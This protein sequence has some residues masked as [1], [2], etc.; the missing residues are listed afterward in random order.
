MNTPIGLKVWGDVVHGW[1]L[2]D[3]GELLDTQTGRPAGDQRCTPV[4]GGR[5][6]DL[7]ANLPMTNSSM[8]N[9]SDSS[10]EGSIESEVI[11]LM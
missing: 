6:K 4:L 3:I 9:P 8:Q 7:D 2:G 5:F 11:Y 1:C 10:T